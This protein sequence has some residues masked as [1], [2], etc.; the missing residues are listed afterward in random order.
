MCGFPFPAY[1][2][3]LDNHTMH[4]ILVVPGQSTKH[5]TTRRRGNPVQRKHYVFASTSFGG[6]SFELLS[7]ET[8]DVDS[9]GHT[10]RITRTDANTGA[11]Q[12]VYDADYTGTNTFPGPLKFQEV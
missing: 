7:T 10:T 4:K 9:L 3:S 8:I 11:S 6:T 12:I 1:D 2:T 5:I